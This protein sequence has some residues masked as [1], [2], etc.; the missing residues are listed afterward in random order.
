MNGR[1]ELFKRLNSVSKT[2]L[3]LMAERE[4][5]YNTFSDR[6]T[7]TLG[8]RLGS[9]LQQGDVIALVGEL[10]SGKTCFAKGIAR[11]LGVSSESVITSPSFSLLNE[12]EGKYTFYHMDAY[13]LETLSDF[14]LAGLDEYF[15]HGGVVALEWAD[16]WPVILPEWS[17]KV[18]FEIV[19]AH[20]RKI[21]LSGYHDRAVD[22]LNN[23]QKQLD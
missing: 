12:Y 23:F 17:V 21:T 18:E 3:K 2:Y 1:A 8:E 11:G 9:V 19:D 6:E 14:V 16:R 20:S 7:S 15:Y 22:T 4:L 5:I 10:G 13:R